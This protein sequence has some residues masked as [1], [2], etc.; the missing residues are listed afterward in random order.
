MPAVS[1][2]QQLCTVI[3]VEWLTSRTLTWSMIMVGGCPVISASEVNLPLEAGSGSD[4]EH[5][6]VIFSH[7]KVIDTDGKGGEVG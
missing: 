6:H 7:G 1:E 3:I 5:N 2:L 4:C